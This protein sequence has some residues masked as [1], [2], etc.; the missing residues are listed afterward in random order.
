MKRFNLLSLLFAGLLI[1]GSLTIIKAQDETP[2]DAPN[3]KFDAQ[4]RPNLLRQLGLTQDQI[5]RVRQINQENKPQIRAAQNR[6]REANRSLDQAI[7]ADVANDAE[8]QA[9][10]K[11]VQAAHAEVLK[12]RSLTELA[13]RKILTPEQLAKFRDVRQQFAQRRENL[14]QQIKN[15]RMNAPDRQRP[16]RSGN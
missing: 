13:V 5:K 8:F 7:Y 1:F 3:N 10:L 11:E 9:R 12:L 16:A 15:R 14:Q 2:P 6:L 4:T